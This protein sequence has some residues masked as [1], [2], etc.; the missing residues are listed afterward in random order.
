[1]IVI[2]KRRFKPSKERIFFLFVKKCEM[3]I[4]I[5]CLHD[6]IAIKIYC[7]QL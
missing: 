7:P 6:G 3:A 4:A 1:M 5:G 2:N